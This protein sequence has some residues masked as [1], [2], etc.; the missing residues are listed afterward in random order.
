MAISNYNSKH[1]HNKSM[2]NDLCHLIYKKK[3]MPLNENFSDFNIVSINIQNTL[4][5]RRERPTISPSIGS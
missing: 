1:A 5:K 4:I 3:S 2:N